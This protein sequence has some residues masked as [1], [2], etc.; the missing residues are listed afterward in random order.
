MLTIEARQWQI[1]IPCPQ[2]HTIW[3]QIYA[4]MSTRTG[5]M[6]YFRKLGGHFENRKLA[7]K[8]SIEKNVT[9]GFLELEGLG[10]WKKNISPTWG[11]KNANSKKAT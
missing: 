1:W 7:E 9:N 2:K 10:V 8:P 3:A 11:K 4:S 5:V 6:R